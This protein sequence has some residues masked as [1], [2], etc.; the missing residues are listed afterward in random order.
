V[1]SSYDIIIIGG[2]IAGLFTASRLRRM[3]YNLILIEKNTLGGVQTLASQGMIHGGQKYTLQGNVTAQAASIATMP[4]RWEACFA[5]HGDIDLSTVK[6]LSETQVM[7]PAQH[8]LFSFL[9]NF[10]VFAASKAVNGETKK[11]SRAAFPAP[12]TRGPVYEMQEKVLE[13][14]SLVAALAKTLQGRIFKGEATVFNNQVTVNGA[15]LTAKAIIFTAGAGN[16]A[17][18]Q[19]TQRRPLRQVMVKPMPEALYGH[20]IVG[21]PKPRVTITS[22]PDGK[23]SFIWYLGG[24]IS[25]EGA[26]LTEAE[27]LAFAKKELQD[28]FPAI[29]WSQKEWATWH[30]E[31]AEAFD[32]S[33]HLPAGPHIDVQGNTL[34]AWPTKMTFAPALADQIVGWLSQNNITPSVETPP[35][36]LPAAEIGLYPWENAT[37]QTL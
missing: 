16:E 19:K 28:I 26:T 31:R 27:T 12:V 24:N 14:K 15:A 10:T 2:G 4:A 22:H 9:S 32:P 23:G 13:T 36:P 7:F 34:I 11:L 3:G 21:K 29:D 35:P 1:T 17:L 33:G 20:G 5:G 30:G 8:S 6:A 37:W 18:S 25:E